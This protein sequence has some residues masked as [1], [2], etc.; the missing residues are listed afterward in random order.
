[1]TIGLGHYLTV[2]D[3]ALTLR[4]QRPNVKRQDVMKQNGGTKEGGIAAVK[5]QSGAALPEKVEG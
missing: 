2:G 3:I 1:M 5:V 4:P